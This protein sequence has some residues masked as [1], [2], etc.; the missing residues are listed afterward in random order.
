MNTPP[1]PEALLEAVLFSSNR[2]LPERE[3]LRISGL[4]EGDLESALASL[5]T[6]YA[7]EDSGVVLRRV[8]GGVQLATDPRCREAVERLR[9]ESR[10][11]FL[12]TAALEVLSCAL[13][14]GPLTRA[15]VSAVRGVNSDAVV[16]SLLDRDLLAEVGE[17]SGSP[18]S[19]ALLDVT[20]EFLVASGARDRGD[21]PPLDELVGPEE[22]AR[23]RERIEKST[24]ETPA[25]EGD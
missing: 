13:Y 1:S 22:L 19:P 21:F 10:P 23:V 15:K 8:A 2:P 16:R 14:L 17:D 9:E 7:T 11:A 24:R 18:G 4:P 5:Q 12:S 25:P 3:L 6:R 20:G